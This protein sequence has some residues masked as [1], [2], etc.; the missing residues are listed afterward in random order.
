MISSS[1]NL[2]F[3][4]PKY[5]NII[6]ILCVSVVA[7]L[8][9]GPFLSD[10]VV[11]FLSLWFLYYSLK[12]K[13]YSVYRNV[14]FYTF[15]AFW[16]ICILS[17]LLSDDIS[18]SLRSS[19]FYVRIGIFALLIT[20][21]IN[22]NRKILDYFYYV[23]LI[24]FSAL[25]VDGYV[26][27]FTSTNLFGYKIGE[28]YRVSSFFGSELI[29][30]SYLARLFPLFF[31]LFIIRSNK[32]PLEVCAVSVLFILIDILIFIAGERTS[33][34]LLNISTIFIIIF[35]SKYKWLR[36]GLFTLSS[37]IIIF[38][39]FNAPKLYN[40]YIDSPLKNSNLLNKDEKINFFSPSHDHLMKTAWNM[41]L[42][43]PILGHGPKL[44]RVKCSDPKYKFNKDMS[45]DIHPHN[46]YFQL[47]AETGFVGFSFLLCLFFYFIYLCLKHIIYY[48]KYKSALFSDYQICL[49]AGLLI[50]IWPL[51]TNGNIFT[52]HLMLFYS[53]QMGFF[54]RNIN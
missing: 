39:T 11:S 13:I 10:L 8:V 46:F 45:C 24:T 21:L 28:N 6:N 20:Y 54:R 29:L 23:F 30:G 41:F 34:L 44:F 49:L 43:K 32:S 5:V 27:Y 2:N 16:L 9:T 19:L 36:L 37:I 15:I 26:Q 47:L 35:I 48:L 40:R 52:N 7:L 18:L 4:S 33:F 3:K 38:L 1:K 51:T 42:E 50:T 17:S 14:Y 31:A 12:N 25:I 22:I 53:L